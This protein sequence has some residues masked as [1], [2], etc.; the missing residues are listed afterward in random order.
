MR[1]GTFRYPAGYGGRIDLPSEVIEN[2][3]AVWGAKVHERDR[4]T[5]LESNQEITD[6]RTDCHNV[7]YRALNRHG[8]WVW[9]RCRGHLERDEKGDPILFAGMIT[10]LGRRNKIDHLTGLLNKFAFEAELQ[11]LLDTSPDQPAGSADSR[12]R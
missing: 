4:Q 8:E 12:N 7:E 6:G 1:T 10:N 3:A 9:L 2:A 5:F 11:R